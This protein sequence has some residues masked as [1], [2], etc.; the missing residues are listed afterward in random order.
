M[1]VNLEDAF[2][3]RRT[4]GPCDCPRQ[5]VQARAYWTVVGKE[6]SEEKRWRGGNAYHELFWKEE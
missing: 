2:G 4:I 3:V 5:V 1:D 6:H